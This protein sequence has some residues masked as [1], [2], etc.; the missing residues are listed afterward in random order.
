ME[1]E[2]LGGAMEVGGSSILLTLANKNILLDV[3][4]RQ[5]TEKDP[6]PNFRVIQEKGGLDAIIISHAHLDHIGCLPLISKEYPHARIYMNHMT[7]ELV[8]VLLFDS[9]K[10]MNQREAE[11]PL[12][13]ENDVTAT[14]N[15][16]FPLHY[17]TVFPIFPDIIVTLYAAGHIAGA[18]CIYVQTKEGT[19]F[20]SGDFCSFSQKTIEG[21]KIPKLRPD[22]AI[23]ESTYGDRLHS[24][25]QVEENELL[26][27]VK[28]CSE[29]KGKMLIPAFALGRAQEVILILKS[30]MNKGLIPAIPVY[31]DGM[32]RDINT[33]FL[34]NPQYLKNSIGKKIWRGIDPFYD[35]HIVAIKPSDKRDELMKKEGA[36]IFVSSSGMLTGGPSSTYAQMIAPMENGYI[37]I[38]GYQDEEAPGRKILELINETEEARYLTLNGVQIPVKCTV[39][40]VGLSAHGDKSEIK[41]LIE[42]MTPGNIFLVH[43]NPEVIE[44]LGKEI[45]RE[46]F[47]RIYMP[48]CGQAYNIEIYNPRKQLKKQFPYTMQKNTE[49]AEKNG[50]ELWSYLREHYENKAFTVADIYYIWSG[51]RK[52]EE[53]LLAPMQNTLLDSVYF[54]CDGKRL[55]LLRARPEE[56]VK[57]DL[58][59]KEWTAQELEAIITELFAGYSYKK[60]S[61][62]NETRSII[63]NFDFPHAV[64]DT[65]KEKQLEFT[66][67]TNWNITINET[68]NNN[69]ASMLLK[70]LFPDGIKKTSFFT[71]EKTVNIELY[72]NDQND[73]EKRTLFEQTTGWRLMIHTDAAEKENRNK[74]LR[75]QYLPSADAPAV[76]QNMALLCIDES[77]SGE[78]YQPYRKS[79]KTD[80]LGKFIELSFI[81][82]MIGKKQAEIIQKI[83]EQ[84]GWRITIAPTVN[85]NEVI[86]QVTLLCSQHGIVLKKNPSYHSL[87][88]SVGIKIAGGE[89]FLGKVK[90]LVYEC[91]GCELVEL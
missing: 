62:I 38:T 51:K 20:Y 4:I 44:H 9:L 90:E 8:R 74:V 77:F 45:N 18:S 78:T 14:L 79:I 13:A 69:A 91:T 25:R 89:E 54:E 63:L 55:F 35:D 68:M 7:K 23:I 84:I 6:I 16:I 70:Q 66:K 86:S 80:Y 29:Q 88:K 5:S 67:T 58:M 39:K 72:Q 11:I 27:L 22:V 43:G 48:E 46:T 1:L 17:E 60:I 47:G 61:F 42:R 83:S 85:Q 36:A 3:G 71:E 33:A 56:D 41:G 34:R 53:E 32:V 30:A 81:S 15:R 75:E 82:P 87:N 24:N 57:K 76:E 12:Y 40:K 26:R 50:Q 73:I 59:P 49:F 31:V 2:F 28:E 19:L 37:V 10:V 65:I 21:I 52:E 64:A